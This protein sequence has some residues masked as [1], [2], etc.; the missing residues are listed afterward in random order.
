[1]PLH[2]EVAVSGS[3]QLLAPERVLLV[4]L[5]MARLGG[6]VAV[7][8]VFGHAAV[9]VRVRVG[10][11]V[12]VAVA[13]A[14]IVPPGKTLA[15]TSLLPLAGAVAL[16]VTTGLFFGLAAQLVF[17]GVQLGGQ[18]AGTQM[19]L[20]LASLIDPQSQSQVTAIA[21]WEHLLALL[22]FLSLD[23]HHLLLRALL[24]SF[25]L[26]PPGGLRLSAPALETVLALG[27]GV[28]EVGARIAAPVLVVLLLTNA[29]LGAL[30]RTIPQLNVFVVGF[31]LNVGVGFLVLAA[32]LPFTF[33]FLSLRFA[34]L[35]P[36]LVGLLGRLG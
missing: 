23:V 29:A 14:G 17:A 30:A 13:V 25:D 33:R 35:E 6:L 4:V 2:G 18:L 11:V 22:I 12:G 27:A 20:G 19:G 21:L 9:P 5:I 34:E 36:A 28:F 15:I 10:L 26:V 3:E 31:P 1:V 32:G 8:P 7:A 16:E 24:H